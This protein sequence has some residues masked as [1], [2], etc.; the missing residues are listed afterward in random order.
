MLAVEAVL[1]LTRTNIAECD[2]SYIDFPSRQLKVKVA[3]RSV[4]ST[5]PDESGATAPADLQPA[6]DAI[7][8][9][10]K[11]EEPS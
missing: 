1:F 7:V 10:H 4:I 6:I 11:S 2:A 9:P 3:D 8:A 5:I